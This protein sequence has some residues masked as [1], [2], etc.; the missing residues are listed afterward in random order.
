MKNTFF[1]ITASLLA[2]SC[3]NNNTPPPVETTDSGETEEAFVA[4][5]IEAQFFPPQKCEIPILDDTTALK[6]LFPGNLYKDSAGEEV[7]YTMLWTCTDCK[8]QDLK[9]VDEMGNRSLFIDFPCQNASTFTHVIG[10]LDDTTNGVQRRAIFFSSC[11]SADRTGRTEP[12]ILGISDWEFVE[13]KW[14]LISFNPAVAAEGTF[15][16]AHVPNHIMP[17]AGGNEIAFVLNGG[18][19]NAAGPTHYYLDKYIFGKV[20]GVWKVLLYDHDATC[21]V[22]EQAL[23]HWNTTEAFTTNSDIL[24]ITQGHFCASDDDYDYGKKNNPWWKRMEQFVQKTGKED[25]KITRRFRYTGSEYKE[26]STRTL[27]KVQ[28]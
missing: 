19:A 24:L 3:K 14:R 15:Q 25:F 5:N 11:C 17:I 10:H 27:S 22:P 12:G 18:N 26:I 8:K 23:L 20:K 21:E 2:V 6:M 28:N 4:K 13:N 1:F 16:T 7:E 9:A